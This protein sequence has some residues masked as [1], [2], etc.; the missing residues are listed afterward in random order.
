M[1][2]FVFYL[3]IPIIFIFIWMIIS[4]TILPLIGIIIPIVAPYFVRSDTPD[5]FP[6]G[7]RMIASAIQKIYENFFMKIL[8]VLWCIAVFILA[9]LYTIYF[10]A[11]HILLKD[12]ITAPIAK[13]ILTYPIIEPFITIGLFPVLDH[14]FTPIFKI[15]TNTTGT[16]TEAIKNFFIRFI[17]V[18][19]EGPKVKT[20]APQTQKSEK[21]P[22]LTN[23]QND[24]VEKKYQKCIKDR[25]VPLKNTNNSLLLLKY[26]VENNNAQ[27]YCQIQKIKDDISIK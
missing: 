26:Q 24:A 12:L 8:V 18:A 5:R 17:K 14:I 7:L 25:S 19:R 4:S 11:Q 22:N 27:I 9:I 16:K 13:S 1:D 21:N 15:Q 20:S 23:E 3:I 6:D 2:A 10:I